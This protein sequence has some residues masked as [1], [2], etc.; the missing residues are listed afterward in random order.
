L[1]IIPQRLKKRIRTMPPDHA[2]DVWD[3]IAPK[4]EFS[5]DP[6]ID[7]MASLV[8]L[9]ARVIEIGCGYGRVCRQLIDRGFTNVIGYDSSPAMI[10]RGRRD[11][12]DLDLR[13]MQG[14]VLPEADEAIDAIV[15]CAALTCIPCASDRERLIEAIDRVLRP[16]GVI[17][18]VEF[19]RRADRHYDHGG[20]FV[21]GLGIEMVHFTLDQLLAEL[22]PFA[23]CRF[24]EFQCQSLTGG[25]EQAIM[26]QGR[27]VKDTHSSCG[28]GC[29]GTT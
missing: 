11:Q 20:S 8:P 22:S 25:P 17:H 3:G 19:S 2:P 26:I 1:R 12:P 4:I 7:E 9:D 13:L 18:I 6:R 10:A 15:C 16:G 23:P 27:K 28:H 5:L 29:S 14:L 24:T 21:S